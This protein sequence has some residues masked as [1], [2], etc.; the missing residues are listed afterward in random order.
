MDMDIWSIDLR[1]KS[2]IEKT[3]KYYQQIQ[4]SIIELQFRLLF[5]EFYNDLH[6]FF[7]D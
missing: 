3:N 7:N 2:S 6:S 4:Y 5:K 1:Q